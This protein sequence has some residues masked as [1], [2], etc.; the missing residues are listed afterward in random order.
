VPS[1]DHGVRGVRFID[2]AVRSSKDKAAW[3]EV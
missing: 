1:V 2:A 3:V